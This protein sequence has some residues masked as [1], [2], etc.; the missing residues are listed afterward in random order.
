MVSLTA[1][2]ARYYYHYVDY[3]ARVKKL[4]NSRFQDKNALIALRITQ[5]THADTEYTIY[6]CLYTRG[7]HK[8]PWSSSN[9]REQSASHLH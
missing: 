6:K 5:S 7:K 3:D 1:H 9:S 8:P 4:R 2:T